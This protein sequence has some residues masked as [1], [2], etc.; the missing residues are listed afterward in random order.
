MGEGEENAAHLAPHHR[1]IYDPLM[2]ELATTTHPRAEIENLE[3]EIE[4]LA[5][6]IESCRKFMLA[7]RLAVVL[8][9]VLVIAGVLG[10]IALSA[11]VLCSAIVAVLGGVVT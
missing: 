2:D 1:T 5:A 6:T 4:K 9:G 3:V 11:L 10:A 7:G 8:G